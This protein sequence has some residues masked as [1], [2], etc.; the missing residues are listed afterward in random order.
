MIPGLVFCS[1]SI[2]TTIINVYVPVLIDEPSDVKYKGDGRSRGWETI[3][4]TLLN[5]Q[6]AAYDEEPIAGEQLNPVGVTVSP[7]TF[8]T[9]S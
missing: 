1:M 3:L 4:R 5:V 9:V 2:I 8:H 7:R 6:R